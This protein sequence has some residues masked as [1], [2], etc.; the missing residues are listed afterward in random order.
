MNVL[1]PRGCIT[2]RGAGGKG[3]MGLPDP[4][5][6]SPT[7]ASWCAGAASFV[8]LVKECEVDSPL[9]YNHC[10]CPLCRPGKREWNMLALGGRSSSQDVCVEELIFM[11]QHVSCVGLLLGVH[12]QGEPWAQLQQAK[13]D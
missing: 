9:E 5:C 11:A 1:Q 13:P 10:Q 12:P 7:R 3:A 6:P 8:C 2:G 4:P